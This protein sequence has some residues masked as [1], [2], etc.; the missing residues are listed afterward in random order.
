MGELVTPRSAGVRKEERLAAGMTTAEIVAATKSNEIDSTHRVYVRGWTFEVRVATE[1]EAQE[2]YEKTFAGRLRD[3][4]WRITQDPE[5]GT[6]IL[7]TRLWT[8]NSEWKRL[9]F[10]V[11]WA[12]ALIEEHG[13]PQVDVEVAERNSRKEHVLNSYGLM[14]L[15]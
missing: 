15:A 9:A 10:A 8:V 14:K 11:E 4:D 1:A 3:G 13:I 12:D 5:D 7:W 2:A 6:H